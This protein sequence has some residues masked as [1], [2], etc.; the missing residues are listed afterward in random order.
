MHISEGVLSAPVLIGGG[1]LAAAGTAVGLRQLDYDELPEVG[2][3]AAAFFMASLVHVPVG[4]TSVHLVL[5]GVCGLLLGWRAFPAILVGLTLQA[6]LFQYGGLT[7]LGVT[8]VNLAAPAVLMGF[9]CIRGVKSENTA[10][11]VTTSFLC[12]AGAVLLSALS[13][14]ACLMLTGTSFATA[15]KLVLA[16]HIPIMIIDGML[17]TMCVEFIR[18][19]RPEMLTPFSRARTATTS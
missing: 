15:A 3:F 8:T 16:A 10:V 13:V 4:P 18:K 19:I 14:T 9:L 17:T 11:R 1:A 6:L 7:V 5:N 12:G 2:V